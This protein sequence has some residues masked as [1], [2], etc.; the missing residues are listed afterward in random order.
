MLAATSIIRLSQAA[1]C[2][3]CRATSLGQSQQ[4]TVAAAAARQKLA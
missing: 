3:G 4:G 2:E 1:N